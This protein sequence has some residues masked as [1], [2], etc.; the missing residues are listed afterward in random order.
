M[1]CW[2]PFPP[3]WM[4][5]HKIFCKS[6]H[7]V[8]NIGAIYAEYTFFSW[9]NLEATFTLESVSKNFLRECMQNIE[10]SILYV[11]IFFFRLKMQT[12]TEKRPS[13]IPVN[14]LLIHPEFYF[15]SENLVHVQ[16]VFF[17]SYMFPLGFTLCFFFGFVYV[18]CR[19]MFPLRIEIG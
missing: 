13:E 17:D 19:E 11:Y 7:F 16:P 4:I 2:K 3:A 18:V 1:N 5:I 15:T 6:S 14:H 9:V 12:N 8:S 10:M